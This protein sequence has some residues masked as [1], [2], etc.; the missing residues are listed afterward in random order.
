MKTAILGCGAIGGL[1][2]GYLSEAKTDVI[3][4]VKD[5]Q[6]AA[7]QK[8]GLKIDG[9]R[10]LHN[11]EVSVQTE[12]KEKVDLAI[13]ATKT[14]DLNK[15]I[16]QNS[17]FLKSSFVLST[18]NGVQADC[19]LKEFFP[20]EKIITSI[21]MFGATFYPPNK[22]VHNFE[23]EWVLGNV[24]GEDIHNLEKVRDFLSPAFNI[25]LSGNIRG[26][27]YL[28][29]FI[30]LNNCIPAI[31]GKSMQQ[32]YSDLDLARLAIQLNREAYDIIKTAGI[33]LTDLPSY[34]KDRIE[35]LTSIPEDKAAAV[36]SGIM[37][38]LSKEPVYGSILQSIKRGKKPEIEYINGEIV[39]L[40]KSNN[41]KAPL[42]EKIVALVRRVEESGFLSKKE[43]LSQIG[44]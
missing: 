19:L 10:G 1:V 20:P 32:V 26:S 5:Y 42:N 4:I 28:K 6:Q 9:V 40:A 31:L 14:D 34:P 22:V 43:L 16:E 24:F 27:K 11:V 30:N 2:L 41:L 38:N 37:T 17:E 36:F 39:N 33:Q 23:G 44:G 3:G 21:V 18:Q 25:V 35:K 12:L 7:L 29:L 15:I 8:E 13:I